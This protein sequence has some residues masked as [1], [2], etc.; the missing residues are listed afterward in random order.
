MMPNLANLPIRSA[1][2]KLSIHTS[3][4]KIIGNGR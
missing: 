2:E 3:H 1:I 4:I